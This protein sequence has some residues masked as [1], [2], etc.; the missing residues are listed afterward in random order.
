M[1]TPES[2]NIE[3][4]DEV[5]NSYKTY[6]LDLENKRITGTVDGYDSIVQSVQKT[7]LIERYRYLIYTT[8]IGVELEKYVGEDINYIKSDIKNTLE[9]ALKI[10]KRVFNIKDLEVEKLDGDSLNIKATINTI[11]GEIYVEQEVII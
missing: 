6:K 8:D 9:D 1:L 10:D 5:Q 2:I 3:E 7:M 11:E 4:T